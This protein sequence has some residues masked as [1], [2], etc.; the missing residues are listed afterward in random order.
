MVQT[1]DPRELLRALQEE[2][3]KNL[4]LSIALSQLQEAQEIMRSHEHLER[5]MALAAQIQSSML[6]A[7]FE[8]PGLEVA[9]ATIPAID[10]GGD[11]YDVMAVEDGCWIGIGDVAGHGL[12][13]GLI[14][15]M[16]QSITAALVRKEP[17]ARPR[18][19]L[20]TLNKVLFDNVRDRLRRREHATMSLLRVERSGEV[21]L[22]GAHEDIV[23]RRASGAC[24]IIPTKGT[25]MGLVREVEA[26]LEE[27]TFS[28][29][30]GDTMVLYTDGLIERR[31]ASGAQFGLRGVR[32]V[33]EECEASAPPA[34]IKDRIVAACFAHGSWREDDASVVV[35]R[36]TS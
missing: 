15:L 10:V 18:E 23:I 7:S 25:W 9:A 19:L 30:V 5:E 1:T 36:K 8:V 17:S 2:R 13:A 3:E 26:H 22:A 16:M 20:G 33:I 6:P 27:D 29:D 24:E 28:F 21:S 31:D 12:T 32:E 4:D 34:D 11:Y 14:M 35:V